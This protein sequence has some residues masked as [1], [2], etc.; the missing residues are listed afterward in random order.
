[1]AKKNGD[2]RTV[3]GEIN[4]M[5]TRKHPP[6]RKYGTKWNIPSGIISTS[7]RSNQILRTYI[8]HIVA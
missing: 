5:K 4:E 1:M 6:K 7:S 8:W 3:C 2:T